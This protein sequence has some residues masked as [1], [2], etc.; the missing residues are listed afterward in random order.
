MINAKSITADARLLANLPCFSATAKHLSFTKAAHELNL[1]QSAV[2]HRIKRLEQLL[3]FDLFL[4]FNRRILLTKE[5]EQLLNVL[6]TALHQVDTTVQDL[7][8]NNLSGELNIYAPPSLALN[9]LSRPLNTFRNRHPLLQINLQ[10]N[11]RTLDFANDKVDLAICYGLGNYQDVD[12]DLLCK[13]QLVPV[14]SALYAQQNNLINQLENIQ[15]CHL[16]HDANAWPEAMPQS[17]WQFWLQQN[18]LSHFPLLNQSHSFFDLSELCIQSAAS[19]QGIAMGRLT[20][21]K[22][23]LSQGQLITPFSQIVQS[24]QAYYILSHKNR[25]KNAAIKAMKS[26]LIQQWQ[27][28]V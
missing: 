23:K 19:H 1:T 4:R 2:S 7:R 6:N 14:C 13:E 12:V 21:I 24:E 9:K 16:L 26:W 15:S 28:Q 10:T 3:G 17:E 22:E 8:N 25:R 11:S 20:L 18:Q 27:M 5:A